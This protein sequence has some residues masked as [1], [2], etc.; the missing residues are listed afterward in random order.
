VRAVRVV[1][2]LLMLGLS[3]GVLA[4][5]SCLDNKLEE[6]GAQSGARSVFIA[7]TRDF[8]KYEDW[9]Q[10]EHDVTTEHG[11]LSGTTTTYVSELPDATTH[12]FAPG[13]ILVK[14]LKMSNSDSVTI[15]AMAKRGTGYNLDGALGWEYF[16][17]QLNSKR[18][19]YILWRGAEPP[20]GEEYQALLGANNISD[21]PMTE[22][23]CND[24]HAAGKDGMLG[25][26]IVELLGKR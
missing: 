20:S 26:D 13:A 6:D 25:D 2:H 11:G 14:T 21:Q 15:H 7:Q 24:C 10:F 4:N 8:A 3:C 9:M 1:R 18:V 5:A 16:E 19:P 22:G 12:Q 23:R 17:L